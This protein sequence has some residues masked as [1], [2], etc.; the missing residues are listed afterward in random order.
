MEALAE[1]EVAEL[2]GAQ[3]QERAAVV[4]RSATRAAAP[5][6]DLV[7]TVDCAVCGATHA[8]GT[9]DDPRCPD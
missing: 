4:G 1:A 6:G 7:F 3:P 2:V 8:A 9:D 5:D